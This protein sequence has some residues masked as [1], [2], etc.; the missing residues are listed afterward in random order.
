MISHQSLFKTFRLAVCMLVLFAVGVAAM[1]R[2]VKILSSNYSANK[3]MLTNQYYYF[4]T[5][6][7]TINARNSYSAM[8]VEDGNTA[9]IY[10]AKGCTL[11][12]RGGD[13][14]GSEGAGC[15]I[16]VPGSSTL[17]IT[18]E[19]KLDVK[20]GDASNGGNGGNGGNG[21]LSVKENRGAGGKGGNGGY[22]G[23]GAAAAIG[24]YGGNGHAEQQGPE[25][26][27]RTSNHNVYDGMGNEG[28]AS[29]PG[30]NGAS[31]GKVY[32]LGNVQVTATPGRSAE[33]GGSAGAFGGTANDKGSGWAFY[34]SSGRGGPGGGGGSG[35]GATYG[36]GGGAPG[37]QCGAT[38]SSGGTYSK[39][40]SWKYYS[41]RG[42]AGG[43]GA[44]NGAKDNGTPDNEGKKGGQASNTIGLAGDH[45]KLYS[46]D[47]RE[48]GNRKSEKAAAPDAVKLQLTLD[49]RGGTSDVNSIDVYLGMRMQEEVAVPHRRGYFFCGYYTQPEG[50][51]QIYDINGKSTKVCTFNQNTTLYAQWT[52]AMATNVTRD[53][54]YTTSVQDA[55]DKANVG[56]EIR[57][58]INCSGRLD[59]RKPIRFDLNGCSAGD[60]FVQLDAN[61]SKRNTLYIYNGKINQLVA[62]EQQSKLYTGTIE[63]SKVEC[64][65]IY[66][67][68]YDYT[69]NSGVY[70]QIF[71]TAADQSTANLM[72]T[73]T[74]KGDKTFAAMLNANTAAPVTA[75]TT[76]D[77]KQ[78][79][80]KTP[81]RNIEGVAP[82]LLQGGYYALELAKQ[83]IS[84]L[85]AERNVHIPG[86]FELKDG[87]VAPEDAPADDY[88]NSVT[89][90]TDFV[91]YAEL[92]NQYVKTDRK[93]SDTTE[94]KLH[95]KLNTMPKALI[96][97][98][99]STT[100]GETSKSGFGLYVDGKT[101]QFVFAAGCGFERSDEGLVKAGQEYYVTLSRGHFRV[102]TRANASN[103]YYHKDIPIYKAQYA[104]NNISLGR[105][106]SNTAPEP[107]VDMT[108]YDFAI[109]ESGVLTCHYVP[110]YGF[111]NFAQHE[112]FCLYDLVKNNVI[113]DQ[114]NNRLALSMVGVCAHHPAYRISGSGSSAKRNCV[115]CGTIGADVEHF[116]Q[117][118]NT[119]FVPKGGEDV[120]KSYRYKLHWVENKGTQL[121]HRDTLGSAVKPEI[122][123][124]KFVSLDVE[125]DNTLIHRYVPATSCS[126][127][128]VYDEVTA[129][130][131]ELTD[132]NVS[133]N[134]AVNAEHQCV[135]TSCDSKYR[136]E[137]CQVCKKEFKVCMHTTMLDYITEKNGVPCRTCAECRELIPFEQKKIHLAKNQYIDL[138]Y[139]PKES[140]V[141]ETTFCVTDANAKGMLFSTQ[142]YFFLR[143][144]DYRLN[145]YSYD[146]GCDVRPLQYLYK[147]KFSRN[148]LY[149]ASTPESD[150]YT[151]VTKTQKNEPQGEGSTL[152]LGAYVGSNDDTNTM[153][154]DFYQ[155]NVYEGDKLIMKLVPAV[156]DSVPGVFDIIK[157]KFF[158]LTNSEKVTDFEPCKKHE[159]CD[160]VKN[161]DEF[162]AVTWIRRCRI[163][164]N[165]EILSGNQIFMITN[166]GVDFRFDVPGKNKA[167]KFEYESNIDKEYTD[168]EVRYWAKNERLVVGYKS[169]HAENDYANVKFGDFYVYD[170]TND[171]IMYHFFPCIW[172]GYPQIYDAIT[173]KHYD[174]MIHSNRA[175]GGLGAQV[176]APKCDIHR[177]YKIEQGEDSNAWIRHCCICDEKVPLSGL[178]VDSTAMLRNNLYM[179]DKGELMY[180]DL[181]DRSGKIATD[182]YKKYPELTRD[183]MIFSLSVMNEGKLMHY[184]LPAQRNEKT[185]AE[186]DTIVYG[187]YDAMTE[188]F[189]RVDGSHAFISG[190]TH[191]YFALKYDKGKISKHCHLCDKTLDVVGYYVDITYKRVESE[192]DGPEMSQRITRLNDNSDN[193]DKTLMPN[194]FKRGAY[195][196][197]GWMVN[198]VEMKPGE[199]LLPSADLNDNI[200][201]AAKWN[202]GFIV[203][204]DT[205]EIN[206]QNTKQIDIVDNGKNIFSATRDFTSQQ[207]SYTRDMSDAKGK[208]WGTLCLPFGVEKSDAI[209]FYLPEKVE[210][211]ASGKMNIVLA[212]AQ[213]VE[214]G[215]PCIF[216]IVNAEQALSEGRLTL[217]P[218]DGVVNVASHPDTQT[219]GEIE[220]VG[221][222]VYDTFVCT[223][224]DTT[225]FAI[226]DDKFQRTERQMTVRPYR[227]HIETKSGSTASVRQ[228]LYLTFDD[229]TRLE[230]VDD[231]ADSAHD[232]YRLDGVK[233]NDPRV[234]G[235]YVKQGKKVVKK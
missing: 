25:G 211:D 121:E 4:V 170:Q 111:E 73:V 91:N 36:I 214:A 230:K 224:S 179:D 69:I 165:K 143:Y 220:L 227:A 104:D 153:P 128:Y 189:T 99:G 202:D 156:R 129:E 133:T 116:L 86:N 2:D 229:A 141:V 112:N 56:D 41:G 184:Y 60:V 187:M 100:T 167:L 43:I 81:A 159:Y 85:A 201:I 6:N 191:P 92:K 232:Y 63:L 164:D 19:G 123:N 205:L 53:I 160:I 171:S 226:S 62:E 18:G 27:T 150:E 139:I 215:M 157:Q 59:I 82:I 137:K 208:T 231:S 136:N 39:S 148:D 8:K 38:G 35:Y 192:S 52:G 55:L 235:I 188:H 180:L 131:V 195:F 168:D 88:T 124:M 11:T 94:V 146:Y 80:L 197:G 198:K 106:E 118:D 177:Y 145:S 102:D 213:T 95:F 134:F 90:K 109:R 16:S 65:T 161:V 98:M 222:Y 40:G 142:D 212:E 61:E 9:V 105:V 151:A 50:G 207:M 216:Q 217:K 114:H 87:K 15:A 34:Y 5:S 1:A 228:M 79:A 154:C 152:R 51:E 23:G 83:L 206:D 24:G 31:M 209:K 122:R 163:C 77:G 68:G 138:E 57:L 110:A 204:G 158:A 125:M 115:I 183:D 174:S 132:V 126:K 78:R 176:Y 48:V 203:N 29:Q 169:E 22:G 33:K 234:K 155:F 45:G 3:I 42:G 93:A 97:I 218:K 13:A 64:A 199:Q 103:D 14:S 221:S 49:Q 196:F 223:S 185:A 107:T 190:C 47:E 70:G 46:L 30:D 162:G 101:G 26:N 84:G 193:S 172:D 72:G 119:I 225:Y 178:Q 186:Q 200:I 74:I 12:V 147:F 7:V 71:N 67:D 75:Y 76:T 89:M 10:I 127:F 28:Y 194:Q 58:N 182:S 233:V 20:G 140:T 66:C 210:T 113:Y 21:W 166:H 144:A 17:I 149:K 108:V 44:V 173:G 117:S 130:Y 32:I 181:Y 219:K 96:P 175:E 54:A 120:K 135:E 37:A